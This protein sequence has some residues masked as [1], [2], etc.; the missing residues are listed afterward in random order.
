[1]TALTPQQMRQQADRTESVAEGLDHLADRVVLRRSAATL[2]AAADQLEAVWR[3]ADSHRV[4]AETAACIVS[5]RLDV[6][7]AADTAP[8]EEPDE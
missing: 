4:D 5:V 8:Q 2:R 1:V 6:I 3:I 7:L